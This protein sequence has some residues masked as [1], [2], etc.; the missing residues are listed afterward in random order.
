M[1]GGTIDATIDS[2]SVAQAEDVTGRVAE[3]FRVVAFPEDAAPTPT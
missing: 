1:T 2:M 3:L